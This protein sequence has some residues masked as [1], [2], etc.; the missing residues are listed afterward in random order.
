MRF[1][2]VV[3]AY[4][5]VLVCVT[6]A[7]PLAVSSKVT[8]FR[9]GLSEY[10]DSLV[11]DSA[12]SS[13]QGLRLYEYFYVGLSPSRW[14]ISG[15]IGLRY[16]WLSI[17]GGGVVP[18]ERPAITA[19]SP[20]G[21]VTTARFYH[22]TIGG[23]VS[24]WHEWSARL[25]SYASFGLYWGDYTELGREESTGNYYYLGDRSRFVPGIGV[26]AEYDIPS[27]LRAFG[28]HFH[29]TIGMRAHTVTGLAL[30][31]GFGRR[32]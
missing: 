3:L 29:F 10:G 13:D 20:A 30:T 8:T 23:D 27:V 17:D 9:C 28:V 24:V 1:S 18:D 4:L 32:E 15:G 6:H 21:D 22:R 25:A 11:V 7:C 26:G 16:N 12:Q 19:G 5:V 2:L 14:T 31:W